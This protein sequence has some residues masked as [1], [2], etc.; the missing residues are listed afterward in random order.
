MFAFT[1]AAQRSL[2]SH[3]EDMKGQSV[4]LV[5]LTAGSKEYADVEEEFTS[6]GLSSNSI[7]TVRQY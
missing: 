3:W 7:I 6:T 1:V 2:P 5:K 4:V